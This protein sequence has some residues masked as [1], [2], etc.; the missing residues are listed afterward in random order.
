VLKV[1]RVLTVAMVLMVRGAASAAQGP[2]PARDGVITGQVV[3]AASGKPVS[4]AIVQISGQ[5]FGGR[6]GPGS[7][8]P[9]RILTGGD[10]R[11]VFRELPSGSFTIAATK[12]GYADGASG[13]RVLGGGSQPVVLTAAQRTAET[14]IRMWKHAAM[15]GTVLDEAGEPVVSLQVVAVRRTFIAGRRRLVP[16]GGPQASTDDRGEYRLSGLPPGEY[17]VATSPPSA[18][19][20][21]S[22]FADPRAGRGAAPGAGFSPG[23]ANG[24]QVGGAQ[25]LVGRGGAIPPPPVGGRIQ[26]YPMV[27]HPSAFAPAQAIAIALGAGEERVGV[28]L[29]LQPVATVRVSGTLLGGAGPAGMV[30]LRLIPAGVEDIAGEAVAPTSV[31]DASGAFTF[32][33]VLPGQYTLRGSGPSVPPGPSRAGER[34]WLAMP[35]AVA[36]DDVDGV[37]AVMHSA[38]RITAR[39]EFEGA[40]PRPTAQ[41]Q[42]PGQFTPPPFTLESDD[43]ASSMVGGIGGGMLDGAGEQMTLGGFAG[44]TYRVRVAAS[45][46]GWMFKSAMLNGV[47]VSET[48]FEFT[49]DIP[50]LVLTYTD[51]WSGMSGVVQGQG[52]AGATVLAFTTNPQAWDNTAANPRRIKST[53]ANA[54]GE[55]GLSSVPPGDYYVMAIAEDPGPEWRDPKTLEALARQATQVSIAEGEHKTLDLRVKEVRQ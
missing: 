48:P 26:I 11:F 8:A 25:L 36:G 12:G 18:S 46:P 49:R 34:Q 40:T 14:S 2:A 9:P 31:S 42:R 15:T 20:N 39:L 53:R 51:R 27:F 16:I 28:D 52:A 38:L 6:I 19:V 54:K 23:T 44:G 30:S 1:L 33:A 45:P 50:D 47:D 43:L 21:T 7:G 41:S 5:P 13:R 17:L 4:A 32:A 22:G 55:F 24:I 3:D 10:G 29:Q 37:V 35:I